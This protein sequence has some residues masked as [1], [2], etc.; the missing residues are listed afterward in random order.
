MHTFG[1]VMSVQYVGPRVSSRGPQ[2][3]ECPRK[4]QGVVTTGNLAGRFKNLGFDAE[5]DSGD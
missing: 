1:E 2:R 5:L 4:S 3:G